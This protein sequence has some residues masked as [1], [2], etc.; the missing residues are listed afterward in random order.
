[1]EPHLTSLRALKVKWIVLSGGEPLMHSDLS[2][3]CDFIRSEGIKLTLLTAGLLLEKDAARVADL[4][5]DLI[6]SIDGPPDIHDQIRGVR[7]A[8]QRLERGIALVRH[9]RPDISIRG[10]CTV[11]KRNC[12]EL[13]NTVSTSHILALNSVSFLAADVTSAAFNRSEGWSEE[14]RAGAALTAEEAN[15][16]EGEIESLIHQC[17]P[18]IESG[19]IAERPEKLRRIVQHFRS[20][21]G[22]TEATSPRCNAPWVSAVIESDGTVK[23]CFFHN[24]V[25]NIH[26]DSLMNILNGDKALKFRERLDVPTN[27]TCRNCVCSLFVP[28]AQNARPS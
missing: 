25:G 28:G 6:V 3:L 18:E 19:F 17:R 22:Q 11:Q 16:L 27:F 4:V 21:L 12:R 7:L 26:N 10:R 24:S 1:M 14:R 5:D 15:A 2:T 23:P 20:E 13:R 8:Y 9:R